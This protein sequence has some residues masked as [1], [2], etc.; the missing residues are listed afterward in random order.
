VNDNKY[1]NEWSEILN[2]YPD[3]DYYS[4]D[5]IN[6]C[7]AMDKYFWFA[8]FIVVAVVFAVGYLVGRMA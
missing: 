8:L 3:K 7:E 2:E 4:D 6:G 1:L 5:D